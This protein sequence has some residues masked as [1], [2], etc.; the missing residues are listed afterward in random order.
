MTKT[1]AITK[2]QGY[3]TRCK[4]DYRYGCNGYDMPTVELILQDILKELK[5]E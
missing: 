3:I 5:S 4:K 2:V 1:K